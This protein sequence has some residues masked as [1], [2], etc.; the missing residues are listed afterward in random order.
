M[1]INGF[2]K[3]MAFLWASSMVIGLDNWIAITSQSHGHL[4]FAGWEVEGFVFEA[5][6]RDKG[7]EERHTV[8]RCHEFTTSG[9]FGEARIRTKAGKTTHP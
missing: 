7:I 4:D 2:K 8:P 3:I 9:A 1:G 6:G 5:K